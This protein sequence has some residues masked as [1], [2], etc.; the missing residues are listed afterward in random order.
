[1]NV[2]WHDHIAANNPRIGILL[3]IDDRRSAIR[4]SKDSLS[5]FAAN[6]EVNDYRFIV[7]LDCWRMCRKPAADFKIVHLES[8]LGLT[9]V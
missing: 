1:M 5:T 9:N 2:I 8:V 4:E 7:S 6:R 3:C